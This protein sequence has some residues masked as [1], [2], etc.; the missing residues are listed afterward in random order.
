MAFE[1]WLIATHTVHGVSTFAKISRAK[2]NFAGYA[3]IYGV[4]VKAEIPP[5]AND[6]GIGRRLGHDIYIYVGPIAG[7]EVLGCFA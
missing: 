1:P 7:R 5:L 3:K 4:D 2:P 6:I